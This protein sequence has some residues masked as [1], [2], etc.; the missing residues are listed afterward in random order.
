[1]ILQP[2]IDTTTGLDGLLS[3]IVANLQLTSSQYADAEA[4]YLEISSWLEGDPQIRRLSPQIYPQGSLALGTTVRPKGRQEFDLDFICQLLVD[5]SRVRHPVVLLDLIERRLRAHP[6]FGEFVSRQN[7]CIRVRFPNKFHL[8]VVPACPDPAMGN[9]CIYVPDREAGGWKPANPRGYRSWLEQRCEVLLKTL[10]AQEQLPPR[11]SPLTKPPLK[12]GIQIVKR[13]RDVAFDDPAILGLAPASCVLT[14]LGAEA[15]RGETSL[16]ATITV[17][18]EAMVAATRSTVPHRILNPA[19]RKEL[20]NEQWF[21]DVKAYKLFSVKVSRF[22]EEWAVLQKER[23]IPAIA[24]SLRRLFGEDVT[25][26]ALAEHATKMQ[27][28][29]HAGTLGVMAGV[30]SLTTRADSNVTRMRTNNFHGDA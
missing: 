15:Y 6:T 17:I 27:G 14:T 24:Q 23:G 12:Q 21:E 19:N 11:E 1:M 13:W 18:V 9:G 2:S 20:L 7:R 4:R 8:D 26:V 5:F 25:N 22:S 28:A 3:S 16:T 29:R 10:E 30:G